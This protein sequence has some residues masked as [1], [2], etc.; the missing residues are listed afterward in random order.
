VDNRKLETTLNVVSAVGLLTLVSLGAFPRSRKR[1]IWNRAGGYSEL[2]GNRSMFMEASH[3]EHG[4]NMSPDNG[5][6]LTDIEHLAVHQQIKDRRAHRQFGL[7]RRANNAAIDLVEDRV[8]SR[9]DPE[10][11]Q[12]QYN[13]AMDQLDSGAAEFG[14]LKGFLKALANKGK[15]PGMK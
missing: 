9:Y 3:I 7:T 2:S 11:V 8:Q 1:K 5:V 6:L 12:M 15:L 14:G 10:T 4:S 13:V